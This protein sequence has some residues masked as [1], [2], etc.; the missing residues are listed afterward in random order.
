[1]AGEWRGVKHTPPSSAEVKES[2]AIILI[3]FGPSWALIGR[4][5]PFTHNCKFYNLHIFLYV[6]LSQFEDELIQAETCS[7]DCIV[8]GRYCV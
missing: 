4:T 3:P 6:L 7:W 5:L 2:R 1:V 8:T